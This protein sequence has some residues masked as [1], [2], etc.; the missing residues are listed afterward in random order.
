MPSP[1]SRMLLVIVCATAVSPAVAPNATFET[2]GELTTRILASYG[3]ISV[4]PSQ[5]AAEASARSTGMPCPGVAPPDQV[6]VQVYIDQFKPL[7]M[8][9]QTWAIDGY[10]RMWWR[11]ERLAF[12]SACTDKLSLKAHER[13]RIW[14]PELYWERARTITLPAPDAATPLGEL[15][16][17]QP[18][19]K[20]WWSRQ[21]SFVLGCDF[22]GTLS[23]LPFDTQTC[24]IMMGLYAESSAIVAPTQRRVR[25]R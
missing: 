23:S 6:E 22:S 8:L 25:P 4:R 9:Q 18:D 21:T 24:T 12:D 3:Q 1:I 5:A 14:K 16:E 7:E 11:D 17:V 2:T 10:L 20:V 13:G 19:G 15:L